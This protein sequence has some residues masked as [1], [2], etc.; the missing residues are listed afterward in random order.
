MKYSNVARLCLGIRGFLHS[1]C[2][3]LGE[4]FLG[5][6]KVVECFSFDY[7]LPH[8]CI[9]YSSFFLG[10][11]QERGRQTWTDLRVS[12]LL[13]ELFS[14]YSVERFPNQGE[15]LPI[16]FNWIKQLMLRMSV[17]SLIGPFT[18]YPRLILWVQYL[19]EA[20]E[21]YE[22]HFYD[23]CGA[24]NSLFPEE[25]VL[26]FTLAFLFDA[27]GSLGIRSHCR[28]QL[29]GTSSAVRSVGVRPSEGKQCG[30]RAQFEGL[31]L[32]VRGEGGGFQ[33][34]GPDIHLRSFSFP[35]TFCLVFCCVIF[36]KIRLYK[37]W[38]WS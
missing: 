14:L 3:A 38:T 10:L 22:T 2:S 36:K 37:F 18:Q 17:C 26:L 16:T 21:I 20:L 12:C 32:A 28:K 25:L 6:V 7:F 5:K 33:L 4:P 23:I 19:W 11:Q 24:L 29:E 31:L 9:F 27:W 30:W 13:L 35:Q 1:S 15:Q 34:G 8:F